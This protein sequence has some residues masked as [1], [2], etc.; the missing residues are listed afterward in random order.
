MRDEVAARLRGPYVEDI[1]GLR[2][3]VILY[4][5]LRKDLLDR[6]LEHEARTAV[7]GKT[8]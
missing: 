7:K 1:V 3:G 8:P 2:P 6:A 4:V 5:Y